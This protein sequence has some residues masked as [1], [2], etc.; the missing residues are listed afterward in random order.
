M[1]RLPRRRRGDRYLERL[2]AEPLFRGVPRHLI[3]VV[4]RCV[5]AL[6]LDAG[7]TVQCL[8]SR[9]TMIVTDGYALLCADDVPIAVV[10]PGGVIDHIGATTLEVHAITD[11]RGF[12][13]ARRELATV[14]TVAPR[15][16][17]A[18]A[19]VD[20]TEIALLSIQGFSTT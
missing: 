5:D 4:G 13:I 9:E 1:L 17:D 6:R 20:A 12:V 16:A 8:P 10:G 7:A 11:L 19:E 15:L 3:V 14:V 18:L 2:A